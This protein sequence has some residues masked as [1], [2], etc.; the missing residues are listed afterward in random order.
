[1][2]NTRGLT[3][4]LFSLLAALND[5]FSPIV[6]SMELYLGNVNDD[7]LSF[8]QLTDDNRLLLDAIVIASN[9][10]ISST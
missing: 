1:M 10:S 9:L 5:G 4:N 2:L 6:R 3:Y 8:G 7:E